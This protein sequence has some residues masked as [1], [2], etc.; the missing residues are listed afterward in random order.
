MAQERETW[1][2]VAVSG[3]AVLVFIAAVTYVGVTFG[4]DGL[5]EQGAMALVGL[6]VGFILLM[7]AAG[8]WLSARDA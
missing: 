5:G 7:S 8:Y 2:E 6:I 3:L 1:V 4:V